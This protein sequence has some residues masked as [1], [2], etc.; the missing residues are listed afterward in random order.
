MKP[1]FPNSFFFLCR[2][3]K[4]L[5]LQATFCLFKSLCLFHFFNRLKMNEEVADARV[6]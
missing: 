2:K 6:T 1:E 3:K 5:R 4:M